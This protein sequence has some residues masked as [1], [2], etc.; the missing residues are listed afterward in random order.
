MRERVDDLCKGKILFRSE[1][2]PLGLYDDNGIKLG[3]L[4]L[5][6]MIASWQCAVCLEDKIFIEINDELKGDVLDWITRDNQ[7]IFCCANCSKTP[8]ESFDKYLAQRP[9]GKPTDNNL[10][11]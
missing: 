6:T 9:V 11:P 5:D 2:M 7:T 3:E 4:M 10:Q 8:G 1:V